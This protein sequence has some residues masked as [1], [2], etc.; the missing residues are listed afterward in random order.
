MRSS[1]LLKMIQKQK[2]AVSLEK[3]SYLAGTI[4]KEKL[5]GNDHPYGRSLSMDAI[6]HQQKEHLTTFYSEHIPNNFEIIVSGGASDATINTIDSLFSESGTFKP[7]IFEGEIVVQPKSSE[8]VD[9]G[10]EYQVV[11]T[12]G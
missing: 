10:K 3:N 7:G 8:Q 1:N 6:D 4:L 12:D 11:H 9:N 5:Y 2:L